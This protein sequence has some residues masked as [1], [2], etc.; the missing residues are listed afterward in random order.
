MESYLLY[1]SMDYVVAIE[2]IFEARSVLEDF[3][4]NIRNP[5]AFQKPAVFWSV[6][7]TGSV[8]VLAGL[9]YV[10]QKYM[11]PFFKRR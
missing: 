5:S 4:S 8:A 2:K 9:S 3:W 10:V 1:D 6:T 11:I 7:I